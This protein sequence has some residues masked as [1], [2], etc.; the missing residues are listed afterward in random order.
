[1]SPLS[2]FSLAL[3]LLSALGTSASLVDEAGG[4]L[5]LHPPSLFE[6]TFS[7]SSLLPLAESDIVDPF[8]SPALSFTPVA[9]DLEPTVFDEE[10]LSSPLTSPS[11][12]AFIALGLTGGHSSNVVMSGSHHVQLQGAPSTFTDVYLTVYDDSSS[13]GSYNGSVQLTISCVN[14]TLT[15]NAAPLTL[16][17]GAYTLLNSSL[18]FISLDLTINVSTLNE[19]MADF[20][21]TPFSPAFYGNA[22]CAYSLTT[23]VTPLYVDAFTF[24]ILH[25]TSSPTPNALRVSFNLSFAPPLTDQVAL[26]TE[27]IT[28]I[29]TVLECD[30]ARLQIVSV[31]IDPATNTTTVVLDFLPLPGQSLAAGSRYNDTAAALVAA[32]VALTSAQLSNTRWLHYANLASVQQLCADGSYRATCAV[33]APIAAVA[34]AA[35]AVSTALIAGLTVAGL[36]VVA[37]TAGGWAVYKRRKQGRGQLPYSP[38]LKAATPAEVLADLHPTLTSLLH[39][40]ATDVQ[41]LTDALAV[42]IDDHTEA[43]ESVQPPSTHSA[44]AS[45]AL[46]PSPAAPSI[47]SI[48]E[49]PMRSRSSVSRRSSKVQ[50]RGVRGAGQDG[51]ERLERDLMEKMKEAGLHQGRRYVYQPGVVLSD[52][53]AQAAIDRRESLLQQWE[54]SGERGRGEI[55]SGESYGSPGSNRSSFLSH[56][57]SQAPITARYVPPILAPRGHLHYPGGE[58]SDD[59]SVDGNGPRFIDAT[60]DTVDVSPAFPSS[61]APLDPGDVRVDI[62]SDGGLSA[63]PLSAAKEPS[64][65]VSQQRASQSK[66]A[67]ETKRRASEGRHRGSE[68][69]SRQSLLHGLSGMGGKADGLHVGY[70]ERGGETDGHTRSPSISTLDVVNDWLNG[71]DE[72]V[73]DHSAFH[74]LTSLDLTPARPPIPLHPVY[75]PAVDPKRRS[76]NAKRNSAEAGK[77]GKGGEAGKTQRIVLDLGKAGQPY[78]MKGKTAEAGEMKGWKGFGGKGAPLMSPL[79]ANAGNHPRM[80]GIYQRPVF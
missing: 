33:T 78:Q 70:E 10:P 19:A 18:T 66:R 23:D 12:H 20:T 62:A 61:A 52:G 7:P 11:L 64:G 25:T 17:S 65:F 77:G 16:L 55:I 28:D 79:M 40:P 3:L 39:S 5:S 35:A 24:E 37:G 14:G 76:W 57:P 69:K 32:F 34:A 73:V 36:A 59:D 42:V 75:Q 8:N 56:S 45:L 68:V 46:G 41:A 49:G 72:E 21:F 38:Q 51:A 9:F 26:Q 29:S 4:D 1:M 48:P 31:F 13:T 54:G 74:P 50:L 80:S 71:E 22:S 2:L 44:R 63:A 15:W 58:D 67:S 6:N 60:A 43:A 27:L 53:R 30:P 47:S